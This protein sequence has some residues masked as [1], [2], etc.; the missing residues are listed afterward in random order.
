M[1]AKRQQYLPC[2]FQR[3][4]GST[5]EEL[6][7]RGAGVRAGDSVYVR[8]RSSDDASQTERSPSGESVPPKPS[9]G[10]IR[11]KRFYPEGPLETRQYLD[12]VKADL[13]R[14]LNA[15]ASTPPGLDVEDFDDDDARPDFLDFP[16]IQRSVLNYGLAGFTG[17]TSDRALDRSLESTVRWAIECFEPRIRLSSV[18]TSVSTEGHSGGGEGRVVSIEI[19]GEETAEWTRYDKSVVYSYRTLR[20]SPMPGGLL[21][22]LNS[23]EIQDLLSFLTS[24]GNKT[25]QPIGESP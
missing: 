24:S 18:R 1:M 3:L 7:A 23:E 17:Q 13:E 5:R 15:C 9:P 11:P 22:T 6:Q 16:G 4:T 12:A 21:D 14:L 25:E 19:R 8:R 2:L 10:P 20:E